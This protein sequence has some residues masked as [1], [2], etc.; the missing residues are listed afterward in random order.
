MNTI[1]TT[2]AREHLGE[3]IDKLKSG[4]SEA[5]IFGRR[6]EPQA[7]LIKFPTLYSKKVSDSTNSNIYSKSFDFLSEEP[8]LYSEKDLL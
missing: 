5:F 7:V 1:S 6:N 8:E 2:Q 4:E 3:Y